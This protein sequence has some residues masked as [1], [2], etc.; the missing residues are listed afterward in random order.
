MTATARALARGRARTTVPRASVLLP[1][2]P[3]PLEPVLGCL[4]RKESALLRCEELDTAVLETLP[5]GRWPRDVL[6]SPAARARAA[7]AG[8]PAGA[9]LMRETAL[10]VHV[11]GPAPSAWC[12]AAPMRHAARPE[13]LMLRTRLDP[14]DVVEIGGARVAGL[15]RCAVD[16]A[17]TA[18]PGRAVC[19]VLAALEHGVRPEEL[20]AALQRCRGAD[21][22]GRG[23]ASSI[24]AQLA[25]QGS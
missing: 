12:A 17:R 15:A 2:R 11:G 9:V 13:R 21:R 7:A 1:L 23:R 19:A 24:I 4:P 18:P 3:R 5:T 22:T 6:A 20:E 14:A 16:L 25:A 8:V 10:W